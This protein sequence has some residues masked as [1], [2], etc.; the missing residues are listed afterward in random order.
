MIAKADQ[1]IPAH[2]PGLVLHQA[3]LYDVLVGIFTLGRERRLRE[4][5]LDIA[6]VKSGEMVLDVGCGTGTLAVA[7]KK[8]VGGKGLVL[9]IDASPEMLV[10]A[11]CKARK[12]RADVNFLEASAQ[13]LP[14]AEES[15]DLV[16]S[17]MM[18]HHLSRNARRDCA[19]EV[20]RVLKPGGR[21]LAVDFAKPHRH[22][23]FAHIHRHG[24][25]ELAEMEATFGGAGLKI[26]SSGPVGLNRLNFV[27]AER[28]R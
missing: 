12:A 25:V 14:A 23:L 22:S 24:H 10:R 26:A 18:L 27:L 6:A 3:V 9:G 7:A 21:V 11:K 1:L 17:S 13:S 20:R 5:I 4:R 16:L 15:V 19:G 2:G 28:P 8:R